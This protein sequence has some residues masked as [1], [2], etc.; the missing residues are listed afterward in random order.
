MQNNDISLPG[1]TTSNFLRQRRFKDL[2]FPAHDNGTDENF[3][4]FGHNDQT[5]IQ[6]VNLSPSC[7]ELID[8]FRTHCDIHIIGLITAVL[9]TA[10]LDSAHINTINS[11]ANLA[12]SLSK[13]QKEFNKLLNDCR[14]DASLAKQLYQ[15]IYSI[16]L[17]LKVKHVNSFLQKISIKSALRSDSNKE[18]VGEWVKFVGKIAM[19]SPST[20]TTNSGLLNIFL[21]KLPNV[22][23]SFQLVS[24]LTDILFNTE[25]MSSSCAFICKTILKNLDNTYT[26]EDEIEIL[27]RCKFNTIDQ[28]KIYKT[29]YVLYKGLLAY[30]DNLTDS[31]NVSS[32]LHQSVLIYTLNQLMDDDFYALCNKFFATVTVSKGIGWILFCHLIDHILCSNNRPSNILDKQFFTLLGKYPFSHCLLSPYKSSKLAT[33]K[34][35]K[36]ILKR[37]GNCKLIPDIKTLINSKNSIATTERS[38]S[39]DEF[40]TNVKLE[41]SSRDELCDITYTNLFGCEIS[42]KSM[43]IEWFET[44]ELYAINGAADQIDF[45]KITSTN[46]IN[47][48]EIAHSKCLFV[49]YLSELGFTVNFDDLSVVAPDDFFRGDPTLGHLVVQIV[50]RYWF[51]DFANKTYQYILSYILFASGLIDLSTCSDWLKTLHSFYTTY[52]IDQVGRIYILSDLFFLGATRP[53]ESIVG[54]EFD[55]DKSDKVLTGFQCKQCTVPTEPT[56]VSLLEQLGIRILWHLL[57]SHNL[58]CNC[59]ISAHHICVHEYNY[60]SIRCPNCGSYSNLLALGNRFNLT[61]LKS[62]NYGIIL[63]VYVMGLDIRFGMAAHELWNNICQSLAKPRNYGDY[64]GFHCDLAT[65][66]NKTSIHTTNSFNTITD[67]VSIRIP[68]ST[69]GLLHKIADVD[70]FNMDS[71]KMSTLRNIYSTDEWNTLLEFATAHYTCDKS[72]DIDT[73]LCKVILLSSLT[74]LPNKVYSDVWSEWPAWPLHLPNIPGLVDIR[75]DWLSLDKTKLN[76]TL[77]NLYLQSEKYAELCIYDLNVLV[78]WYVGKL[79]WARVINFTQDYQVDNLDYITSR[80]SLSPLG[81]SNWYYKF[82]LDPLKILLAST[83]TNT[84]FSNL[85]LQGI[86]IYYEL[87]KKQYE[88][89]SQAFVGHSQLLLLLDYL[90][91][92]L[93]SGT[94]INSLYTIYL[95]EALPKVIHGTDILFPTITTLLLSKRTPDF[96]TPSFFYPLWYQPKAMK[97]ARFFFL[98]VLSWALNGTDRDV[99]KCIVSKLHI[100]QL[101]HSFSIAYDHLDPQIHQLINTI[102]TRY[103]LD[104]LDR[105]KYQLD[106]PSRVHETWFGLLEGTKSRIWARILPSSSMHLQPTALLGPNFAVSSPASPLPLFSTSVGSFVIIISCLVLNM[107]AL[108]CVPLND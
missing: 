44:L 48:L 28:H 92:L 38:E 52:N 74:Y 88:L 42:N 24:L 72:K 7:I 34:A 46:L 69:V 86:S 14:S 15:L 73:I 91:R 31:I 75:S 30:S 105:T 87:L 53:L 37:Y 43:L 77:E 11:R 55:S 41:S 8:N 93:N 78:P 107:A 4:P 2:Y 90:F 81:S 70:I 103:S 9:N 58:S 89:R 96:D 17:L 35:I 16:S 106:T 10:K 83:S 20:I 51:D 36:A 84:R 47:G 13:Q 65:H 98:K 68:T 101:L 82:A 39:D 95:C 108:M 23:S 102:V 12:I 22:F 94:K 85:A 79:Y 33:L 57:S 32:I 104:N 62:R 60:S 40:I 80:F 61:L 59:N 49:F 50:E 71:N 63:L 100:V 76:S 5:I 21:T 99:V 67:K 1:I 56:N 45:V 3:V 27:N 54:V 25:S 64:E 26:F 29:I 19:I 18:E 97:Q 6:Y 66:D